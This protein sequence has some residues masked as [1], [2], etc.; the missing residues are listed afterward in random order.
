MKYRKSLIK[1]KNEI[2]RQRKRL[3]KLVYDPKSPFYIRY[4]L[5]R[6]CDQM[7]E[8]I[9]LIEKFLNEETGL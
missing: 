2:L 7:T 6:A 8:A 3:R 4:S 9:G 1:R 5:A